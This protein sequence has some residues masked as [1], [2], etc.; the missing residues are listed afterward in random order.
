MLQTQ[1]LAVLV[2]P[3]GCLVPSAEQVL[4]LMRWVRRSVRGGGSSKQV[5][6][7]QAWA[8]LVTPG[9]CSVPSAEQVLVPVRW[10]R[11]SVRGGGS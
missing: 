5:L 11:I 1:A 6:Q 9:G 7:T 2:T 4:V 3:G 8:V 10:V